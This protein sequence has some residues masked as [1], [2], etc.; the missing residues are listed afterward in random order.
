MQNH[1][2]LAVGKDLRKAATRVV[3]IEE[4]AKLQLYIKQFGGTVTYLPDEWIKRL[5]GVADFM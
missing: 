5:E 1:G 4:T 2:L 3:M